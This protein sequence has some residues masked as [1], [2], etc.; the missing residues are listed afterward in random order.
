[1]GG[2][3]EVEW[4]EVLVADGKYVGLGPVRHAFQAGTGGVIIALHDPTNP[5]D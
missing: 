3:K 4:H 5:S 2:C 1:V